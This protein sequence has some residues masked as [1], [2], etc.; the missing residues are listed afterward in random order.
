[1]APWTV[2]PKHLRPKR[3]LQINIRIAVL[4]RSMAD[5]ICLSIRGPRRQPDGSMVDDDEF[6]VRLGRIGDRTTRMRSRY[7]RRALKAAETAG[8]THARSGR[9]SRFTG[10]RIGR[11]GA[12]GALAATRRHTAGQRRVVIKTRVVRMKGGNVGAA[13]AHLRYLQRDGV[14]RQGVP[15]H[16][17]D[18]RGDQ[19]DGKAFLER[20]AGDRHQFRFIVSAEDA[21]ALED[22]KPFV[23]DL[24]RQME[25]DLGTRLDWVAVDHFNT[26]HPHTHVVLRGQD[27]QG[28]D[29][30]IARD[31]ISHGMRGRASELITRELGPETEREA[32]HK[33]E[34]EVDQERF[35][36]LDRAIL[37]AAPDGVLDLAARAERDPQRHALRMGRLR[38]LERLG[39]AQEERPGAWRIAADAEPALR[40]MGERG[41]IIKTMHRALTGAGIERAAA[42]RAIFDARASG[43][44]IVGRLIAEGLADE[45]HERRYVIVDGVDGRAHY[46]EIGAR[47]ANEDL[48]QRG[49]VVEVRGRSSGPR[50][51]DQTIAAIAARNSGAYATDRHRA[52]DPRASEEFVASHVRRLEA[53]RHAG[54]VSRLDDGRWR[55]GTDYLERAARFETAARARAPARIAALSWQAFGELADAAGATWLDRQLVGRQP[56][57][58]RASGFGAE[59]EEALNR[60]RR[61]LLAQ[62]LAREEAGRV[63]Y[64]RNLVNVLQRRELAKVGTEI[65]RDT[66]LRYTE[67]RKGEEVRGTYRRMLTLSSDRFALIERAQDFTLVPW[68]PVLERA[69]GQIVSGIVGGEG[70]SWSIG[71]QRSLGL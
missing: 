39:L 61:W 22:L 64:A 49:A 50:R 9:A 40:R 13:R 67:A 44:R 32:M 24:M 53:L 14:T 35:T 47:A 18:A 19:A 10:T 52:F 21:A 27:A 69:K 33:L 58:V 25:A 34:R 56:E 6:Q 5:R 20:G 60:R 65:A 2:T 70:I 16:L 15:G 68:R 37:R 46:A 63:I 43:A 28:A 62:G 36:R 59:V 11:G 55:V 23:R 4:A 54:L 51:V 38:K 41:D 48:P 12:H 31:Y 3:L 71:R 30:V 17:Y 45:W 57:T 66:G 29:L 7:L 42:D 26:G 1:L 8:G